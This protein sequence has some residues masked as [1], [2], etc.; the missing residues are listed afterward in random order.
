MILETCP[1]YLVLNESVTAY[2]ILRATNSDLLY[3]QEGDGTAPKAVERHQKRPYSD[4]STDH[5]SF[6]TGQKAAGKD[7]FIEDLCGC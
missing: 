4:V 5:C 7:D 2:R 3:Y 6:T 1:Q